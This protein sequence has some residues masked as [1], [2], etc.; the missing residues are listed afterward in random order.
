MSND[1]ERFICIV[2]SYN[3]PDVLDIYDE[4]EY[5]AKQAGVGV[6][7]L[8]TAYYRSQESGIGARFFSALR[9]TFR[10]ASL[11]HEI[12]IRQLTR[13]KPKR[14]IPFLR[15]A[16]AL[17]SLMEETPL[18]WIF[19]LDSKNAA[20]ATFM[21]AKNGLIWISHQHGDYYRPDLSFF[22]SEGGGVR[23]VWNETAKDVIQRAMP[24]SS[25]RVSGS[26]K[27]ARYQRLSQPRGGRPRHLVFFDTIYRDAERDLEFASRQADVLSQITRLI[28]VPV[29]IKWHPLRIKEG[30]EHHRIVRSR[31]ENCR[32]ASWYRGFDEVEFGITADSNAIYDAIALG[33]PCA[34]FPWERPLLGLRADFPATFPMKSANIELQFAEFFSGADFEMVGKLQVQYCQREI[35]GCPGDTERS[36]RTIFAAKP[37]H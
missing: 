3:R 30:G 24:N 34:Y 18:G 8:Y 25:I 5:Y 23:F 31:Y 15:D 9:D 27:H 1:R 29:Y 28:S 4:V 16:A 7:R 17:K 14:V 11:M 33:I 37:W 32:I 13:L 36:F 19:S 2:Y 10:V 6:V 35:F 21:A 26:I 22:D 12:P 20:G